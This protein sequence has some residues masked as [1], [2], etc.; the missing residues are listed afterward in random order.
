M[1]RRACSAR[2]THQKIG[3]TH[4]DRQAPRAVS[5][6]ADPSRTLFCYSRNPSEAS[7]LKTCETGAGF[8]GQESIICRGGV[9]RP[10]LETSIASDHT[11]GPRAQGAGWGPRRSFG[12]LSG[13]SGAPGRAPKGSERPPCGPI[14][15]RKGPQVWSEAKLVSKAYNRRLYPPVRLNHRYASSRSPDPPTWDFH[16][17]LNAVCFSCWL[18]GGAERPKVKRLNP[19]AL[20][21][22]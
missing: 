7:R 20:C 22:S 13:V 14:Q 10:S 5:G 16:D 4:L 21:K 3:L 17:L 12:A 9:R 1:S 2:N 18:F 19:P 11:C 6:Q 8:D 15:A